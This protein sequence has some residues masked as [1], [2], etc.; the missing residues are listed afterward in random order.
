MTRTV[1]KIKIKLNDHAAM[2]WLEKHNID[3]YQH[4]T[5]IEWVYDPQ[6]FERIPYAVTLDRIEDQLLYL[7]QRSQL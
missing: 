3:I 7:L 6:T 2:K 4:T 5:P 1:Q